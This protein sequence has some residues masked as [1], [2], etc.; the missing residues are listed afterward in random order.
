MCRST[1]WTTVP[2]LSRSSFVS[3]GT[4]IVY[5]IATDVTNNCTNSL[6][7][8]LIF[9]FCAALYTTDASTS[10]RRAYRPWCCIQPAVIISVICIYIFSILSSSCSLGILLCVILMARWMNIRYPCCL[11]RWIS[12][13]H[14]SS[15][16]GYHI[17]WETD[18]SYP[19][20]CLLFLI[21]MQYIFYWSMIYYLLDYLL[22]Y[23]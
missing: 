15:W 20:D 19:N 13:I 22:E 5:W 18:E 7:I 10:L 23:D 16:Y 11:E 9:G 2:F 14:A 21:V 3:K 1:H 8:C 12:D 4:I 6:H 17:W